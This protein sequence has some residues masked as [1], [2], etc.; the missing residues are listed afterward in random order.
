MKT[1]LDSL[2]S[3]IEEIEQTI[4]EKTELLNTKKPRVI[5]YGRRQKISKP[6]SVPQHLKEFLK[7]EIESLQ[8][9]KIALQSIYER[10]SHK[11][12]SE[13][14]WTLIHFQDGFIIINLPNS[15]SVDVSLPI[16]RKSFNYIKKRIQ[17][18]L[19]P[20]RISWN[21]YEAL[22]LDTEY[23]NEI[24]HYL[25]CKDEL[26]LLIENE[27]T[28][29]SFKLYHNIIPQKLS[30]IYFPKDKTEYLN[31]FCE[32]QSE[33]YKIIPVQEICNNNIEDSFLFTIEKGNNIYIV[34]ENINPNRA[35]YIF[36]ST[37]IKYV[38]DLQ[39]IFDYLISDIKAKRE[40][41]HKR[42]IF[43]DKFGD[44]NIYNH[45]DVHIWKSKIE[46]TFNNR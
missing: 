22:V 35:T 26:E 16:S 44:Y 36:Q 38:N 37:R 43:K 15:I 24:L 31:Y 5:G 19:N 27:N 6:Q 29:N 33:M 7:K 13:I 1:Y 9:R 39:F 3:Q 17:T 45:T 14:P 46:A 2:L 20:L 11:I 23:F 41:L 30:T 10:E 42:N 18:R 12:I 8:K 28:N 32:I 21:K 25:K 4:K 40:N 34:W